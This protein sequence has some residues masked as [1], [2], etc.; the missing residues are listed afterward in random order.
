MI[1]LDKEFMDPEKAES[2]LNVSIGKTV[3]HTRLMK[4]FYNFDFSTPEGVS[5]FIGLLP[6]LDEGII[7]Q[8]AAELWPGSVDVDFDVKRARFEI[9][10][11]LADCLVDGIIA[12][13]EVEAEAAGAASTEVQDAEEAEDAEVSP[14]E[15]QAAGEVPPG[16][17]EE[18]EEEVPGEEAPDEEAPPEE[19]GQE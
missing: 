11:Y 2:L 7:K 17:E 16:G 6:I 18:E 5:S 4:A 13:P 3:N 1:K 12:E 19:E 15:A 14:A 10:G 8:A 9:R